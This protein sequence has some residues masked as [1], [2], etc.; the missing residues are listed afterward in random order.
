MPFF[1]LLLLRWRPSLGLFGP[2]AAPHLREKGV[3]C[4]LTVS[5]P[6]SLEKR[7]ETYFASKLKFK[8][9]KN[10]CA[11]KANYCDFSTG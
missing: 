1:S 9:R 4:L 7:P 10:V 5:P 2:D 6:I 8:Y 3:R 11:E